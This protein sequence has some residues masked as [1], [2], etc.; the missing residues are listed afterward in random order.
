MNITVTDNSFRAKK[1]ISL[2]E[3]ADKSSDVMTLGNNELN[4]FREY[5]KKALNR[6]KMAEKNAIESASKIILNA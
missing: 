3:I 1:L 6:A 2:Q 4:D 5:M